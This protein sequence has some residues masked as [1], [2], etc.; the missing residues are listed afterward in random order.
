VIVAYRWIETVYTHDMEHH[1]GSFCYALVAAWLFGASLLVTLCWN[2]VVCH[3]AK[4]KT[5]KYW[6]S[7]LFLGTLA[8]F[9]VPRLALKHHMCC[10][11]HGQCPYSADSKK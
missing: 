7:L 6:Q 8:S 10:K 4:L 3:V 1:C 2:N 11:S 5:V 9:A